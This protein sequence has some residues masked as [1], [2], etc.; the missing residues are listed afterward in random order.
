MPGR[1][2]LAA[3]GYERWATQ[4]YDTASTTLEH[5]GLRWSIIVLARRQANVNLPIVFSSAKVDRF[6]FTFAFV[7]A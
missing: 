3:G 7:Q 6:P 4:G 1:R 2:S 5:H